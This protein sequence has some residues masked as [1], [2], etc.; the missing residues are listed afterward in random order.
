[1]FR[2]AASVSGASI[3]GVAANFFSVAPPKIKT[4]TFEETPQMNRFVQCVA[5]QFLVVLAAG[6]LGLR[7]AAG[8]EAI[9]P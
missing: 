7:A 3:F 6:S 1:M 4:P 9:A 5:L 2:I 8:A